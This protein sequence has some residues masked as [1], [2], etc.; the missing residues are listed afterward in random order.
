[1][2]SGSIK[3]IPNPQKIG[4]A[5]APPSLGRKHPR[6]WKTHFGSHK[7]LVKG[8]AWLMQCKKDSIKIMILRR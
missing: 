7:R 6:M 3:D 8:A 5:E 4:D 2:L 1:M